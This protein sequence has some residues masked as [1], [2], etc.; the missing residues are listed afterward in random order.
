MKSA[1]RTSY[2]YQKPDHLEPGL[3]VVGPL[4]PLAIDRLLAAV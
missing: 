2:T 4:L 3:V 1:N